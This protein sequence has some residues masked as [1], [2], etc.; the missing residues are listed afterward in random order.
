LKLSLTKSLSLINSY[1][2]PFFNSP[3]SP[4]S[5]TLQPLILDV[6]SI[7]DHNNALNHL[8]VHNSMV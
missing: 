7:S 2:L 5:P 4:A 8:L 1:K 3:V 6:N